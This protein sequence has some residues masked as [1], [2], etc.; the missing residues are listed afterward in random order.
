MSVNI[1]LFALKTL[2]NNNVERLWKFGIPSQL[3]VRQH[4]I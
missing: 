2:Y 1:G 3:T 4:E